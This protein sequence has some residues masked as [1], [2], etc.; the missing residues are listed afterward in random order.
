MEASQK[1]KHVTSGAERAHIFRDRLRTIELELTQLEA[2]K[3]AGADVD[4]ARIDELGKRGDAL[5]EAADKA[6]AEDRE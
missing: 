2:D 4:D 3:L 5:R 6:A 1:G